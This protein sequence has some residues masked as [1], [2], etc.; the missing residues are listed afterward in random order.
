MKHI[1]AP[2]KHHHQNNI[3]Q[4]VIKS[5]IKCAFTIG[6]T[7]MLTHTDTNQFIDKSTSS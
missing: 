7:S 4:Q 3:L 2:Q 1:V 6:S 5:S